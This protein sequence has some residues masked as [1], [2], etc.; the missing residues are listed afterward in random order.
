MLFMKPVLSFLLLTAVFTA[1]H[2]DITPGEVRATVVA[3]D[4]TYTICGGSWLLQVGSEQRRVRIPLSYTWPAKNIL[5]RYVATPEPNALSCQFIQVLSA[6]SQYDLKTKTPLNIQWRL[7]RSGSWT[8]T[9]D[10]WVMS[11]TSYQLLHPAVLGLQK[12]GN[13][14]EIQL[15]LSEKSL[16]RAETFFL[17]G[18]LVIESR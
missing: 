9:S 4:Y 1:C 5:I 15:S 14:L 7:L 12:Y 17:P 2:K 10:L 18:R 11:P 6:R 3:F 8:R 13:L 16:L